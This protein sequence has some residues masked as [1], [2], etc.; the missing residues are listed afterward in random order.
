MR[1][2]SPLRGVPPKALTTD[3]DGR[4]VLANVTVPA[5]RIEVPGF[6]QTEVRLGAAE[7]AVSLRREAAGVTE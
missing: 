3:G 6:A 1:A 5:I 4:L 2:A 7:I